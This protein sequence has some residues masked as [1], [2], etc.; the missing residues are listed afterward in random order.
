MDARVNDCSSEAH[1]RRWLAPPRGRILLVDD[2]DDL[3]RLLA[4]ILQREGYDVVQARDGIGLF[5]L[6]HA[7]HG[8][9][10]AFTAI[11]TDLNLPY[12]TALEVLDG[13]G[14]RRGSAPVILVTAYGDAR[15]RAAAQR[16]G[17]V[18]VLDKPLAPDRLCAV[19]AQLETRS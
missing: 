11:V 18:V 14:P 16:M 15:A 17:A 9:G 6:L 2:D 13:L 5:Q 7:T 10:A 19:L 8:G 4:R 12:L 3:R 1:F